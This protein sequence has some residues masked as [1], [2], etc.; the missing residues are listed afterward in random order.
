MCQGHIA[1]ENPILIWGHNCV[2]I[3]GIR[4]LR[5]ILVHSTF[6]SGA[7]HVQAEPPGTFAC[8]RPRCRTCDFTGRTATVISADEGVRLKGR[9]DR[10]AAGVVYVIA[11]QRC[12]KM[13]IGE[14]GR[15]LSDRFG[16]HLRSV[17][18]Y[19]Q[20]PR[21]Q[22]GGFP[23]AE[24]FNL[25]DHNKIQDMRVSVVRKVNGGTTVRQREGKRL[26]FQLKTLA[27]GGLNV[28]FKFYKFFFSLWLARASTPLCAQQLTYIVSTAHFRLKK[29]FPRNVSIL[30]TTNKHFSEKNCL[31]KRYCYG[32][33]SLLHSFLHINQDLVC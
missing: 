20:H 16:E 1:W 32:F 29:G 7:A 23:V 15:R 28:D 11:C 17:E 4:G 9:F 13:Y 27:P 30:S 24:H 5:D 26:I 18:D 3:G 25:P 22:G 19:H 33:H 12:H 2:S 14:T 10:T 31:H 21:Y 6:S 8:N